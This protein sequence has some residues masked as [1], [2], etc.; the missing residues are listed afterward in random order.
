MLALCAFGSVYVVV[1]QQN[2]CRMFSYCESVM[3]IC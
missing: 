3:Y 1:G 2:Y